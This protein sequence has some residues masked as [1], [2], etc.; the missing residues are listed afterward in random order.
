[1]N[2]KAAGNPLNAVVR[3]ETDSDPGLLVEEIPAILLHRDQIKRW[4]DRSKDFFMVTR[5]E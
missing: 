1:M 5:L 3:E 4:T 2:E